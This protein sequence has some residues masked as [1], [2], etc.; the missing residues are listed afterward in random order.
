VQFVKDGLLRLE[1]Q[2]T[3]L[4]TAF[5]RSIETV[6]CSTPTFHRDSKSLENEFIPQDCQD[7]LQF[8]GS[9]EQQRPHNV[10]E[11]LPA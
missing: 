8:L 7:A 6:G 11:F 9:Q 1:V 5:P 2:P 10:G 3:G 4:P